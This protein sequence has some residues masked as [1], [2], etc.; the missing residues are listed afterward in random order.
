MDSSAI[1]VV[2]L[3]GLVMLRFILL[4]LG[5]ALI[6]RPVVE[7]P[8][9]FA[10]TFAL[11]RPWLCRLIPWLEWRWCPHCGWSGPARHED[12]PVPRLPPASRDA[13]TWHEGPAWP[14]A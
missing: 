11:H 13:P 12:R 2:V 1:T 14:D 5:A 6:I 7:C 9:C 10:S 3:L 4:G 8:A